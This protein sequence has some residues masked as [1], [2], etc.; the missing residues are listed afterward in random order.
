MKANTV[1]RT[2]S[3]LKPINI[4]KPSVVDLPSLI[5]HLSIITRFVASSCHYEASLYI[6]SAVLR[7]PTLTTDVLS[8]RVKVVHLLRDVGY[9]DHRTMAAS[10]VA[11]RR[12]QL[13]ENCE[14]PHTGGQVVSGYS[15]RF[16]MTRDA[17]Y[18][19]TI[20]TYLAVFLPPS[21]HM[22][23]HHHDLADASLTNSGKATNAPS[24][25]RMTAHV[26]DDVSRPRFSPDASGPSSLHSRRSSL[27]GTA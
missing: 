8:S 20:H 16:H 12:R 15:L 9:R 23:S 14:A 19:P 18:H 11:R 25:P 17:A 21:T 2:P 3:I 10:V 24:W 13:R 4:Y 22:L 26:F 27:L 7:G 6:K 5:C 1:A